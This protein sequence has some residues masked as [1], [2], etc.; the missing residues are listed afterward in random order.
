MRG[1]KKKIGGGL[2][3]P[4]LAGSAATEDWGR[5]ILFLLGVP[6]QSPRT[7]AYIKDVRQHL[8]LVA[9]IVTRMGG[10]AVGGSGRLGLE[11]DRVQRGAA[12]DLCKPVSH[13]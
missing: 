3:P 6:G 11:R 13:L 7:P 9:T 4:N 10:D 1:S 5:P 8:I 2:F 12:K